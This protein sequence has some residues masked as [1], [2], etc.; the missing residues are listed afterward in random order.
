MTVAEKS[1]DR[2]VIERARIQAVFSRIGS[3]LQTEGSDVEL[4][5]VREDRAMM[6]D[7]SVVTKFTL[8]TVSVNKSETGTR[9]PSDA[10]L[11]LPP[12][13]TR[14]TPSSHSRRETRSTHDRA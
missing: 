13:R 7:G 9:E 5:D 6:Q 10:C 11:N 3:L 14:Y 4:V 12:A 8:L 2:T 1:E